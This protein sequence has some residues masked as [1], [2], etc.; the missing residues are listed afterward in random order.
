MS[1]KLK[2]QVFRTTFIDKFR[3]AGMVGKGTFCLSTP[4]PNVRLEV[5][6]SQ[7][8]RVMSHRLMREMELSRKFVLGV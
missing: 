2:P 5:S 7:C 3:W 6:S 1:I 8:Q 4:M